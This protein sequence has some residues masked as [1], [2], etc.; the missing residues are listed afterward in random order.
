MVIGQR[1]DP[2]GELDAL[3]AFAGR[4]QE[5]LGRADHFP[6]AGMMLAAPEF[7][8]PERVEMLDE[9]EIAAELQH[10]MLTDRM[11]GGEERA[12]A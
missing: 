3:A 6:A 11:V 12:E 9:V 10:R 2:G 7:V 4:G 8:V 5:H 1:D